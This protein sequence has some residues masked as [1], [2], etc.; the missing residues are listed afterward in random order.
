VGIVAGGAYDANRDQALAMLPAGHL[1]GTN[2]TRIALK[3][4][5]YLRAYT[6]TF[7]ELFAPSLTKKLIDQAILDPAEFDKK[8]I[9]TI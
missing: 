1:F 7:I 2:T 3:K 9:Y 6:Y 8:S 5:A 4:D